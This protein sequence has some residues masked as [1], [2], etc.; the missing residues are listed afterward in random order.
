M[1]RRGIVILYDSP[2]KEPSLVLVFL[3]LKYLRVILAALGV[4]LC[5]RRALLGR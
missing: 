1:A 2:L 5:D 3:C 4:I